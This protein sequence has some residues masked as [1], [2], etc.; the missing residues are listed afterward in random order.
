[1][2]NIQTDTITVVI[3]DRVIRATVKF[4]YDSSPYERERVILDVT[5]LACDGHERDDKGFWGCI[6]SYVQDHLF[7]YPDDFYLDGC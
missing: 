1:M 7:D 4:S 5:V 3:K 2:I 6:D